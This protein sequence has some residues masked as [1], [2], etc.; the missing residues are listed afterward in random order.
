MYLQLRRYVAPHGDND[1]RHGPHDLPLSHVNIFGL[2]EPCPSLSSLAVFHMQHEFHRVP[3]T[4]LGFWK[5]DVLLTGEGTFIKAYDVNKKTLLAKVEVFDGQAVHGIIVEDGCNREPTILVWGGCLVRR[6][7]A[8]YQLSVLNFELGSLQEADDWILD[9][10]FAPIDSEVARE[11]AIV[12]AHN[13]LT[14]GTL[15]GSLDLELKVLLPGSNCILYAAHVTWLSHFKCLIASGTAFGD[16][17][18]WS[19]V[20]NEAKGAPSVDHETHYNFSAHDGS[21]F[22]VQISSNEVASAL[23]GRS[24]VLASC[25]DDRTIR[26]W[27]ISDLSTKRL[28]HA[29]EERETGFGPKPNGDS[30]GPTCLAK[31]MG[32]GSRIW[33]ARFLLESRSAKSP[34]EAPV[35]IEE[36]ST[37]S[38]GEDASCIFWAMDAIAH[39]NEGP[40]FSM[41]QT[42]AQKSHTGK[43]IWSVIIDQSLRIAT[44]GADG[45]IAIRSWSGPRQVNVPSEVDRKLLLCEGKSDNFK[46][47]AF[48]APNSLLATTDNGR[49]IM[50]RSDASFA[51]TSDE[52]SSSIDAL[53]GYSTIASVA[54]IAFLAGTSG[55]VYAYIHGSDKV[56]KIF[57][58]G[59]KVATLFAETVVDPLAQLSPSTIHL[60]ITNVNAASAQLCVLESDFLTT[61]SSVEAS[62]RQ[63]ELTLPDNFVVTSFM[64]ARTNLGSFVVLGSRSGS[65]AVFDIPLADVNGSIA[66]TTLC[67]LVH[68]KEA[69]TSIAFARKSDCAVNETVLFSTGRDGTY[70]AHSLKVKDHKLE[71]CLIHQLALP[72][73]PNVEGI[74]HSV[75]GNL[76]VWGFRSKQFVVFDI[77]TQQEVMTVEC[78]GAHRTWAFQPCEN[79]GTFFWIKA[80]KLY[81]KTQRD[82]PFQSI[83]AGGHGREI[84]AVAVSKTNPQLIA[85]GAEDTNIKLSTYSSR[86]SLKTLHT[87]QKH[88][89]GTQH[90]QWSADSNHLFSSGGFEEFFIWRIASGVPE[91]GIGVVCESSHPNSGTSDLR[92]TH[93]SAL[94]VGVSAE[95]PIFRITMT[96]SDSTLREWSYHDRTWT[97]LSEGSYL[98]SCLTQV[99]SLSPRTSLT[100][101]IDAKDSQNPLIT[102]STDGHLTAWATPKL[103]STNSSR[104]EQLSWLS[105]HQVHQN[106]ILSLTSYTLGDDSILLLSTGDDNALGITRLQLPGHFPGSIPQL[107]TLL[108]P[109]AHAAAISGL[110]VL[111]QVREPNCVTEELTIC[112]TSVDQRLKAWKISV[113][114][115]QQGVDGIEVKYLGSR[116]S[117][118]ADGA[119][120]EGVRLHDDEDDDEA[121]GVLVYGVGMEVWTFNDL[122][123]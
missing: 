55:D 16:V 67:P 88:N 58:T 5:H 116:F 104:P 36:V 3:V 72:F 44:G 115:A 41:R 22:G 29:E 91:L 47:F 86:N 70:A 112:T 100:H 73:G 109:R 108:I 33:S 27:D 111:S 8:H 83:N 48:H 103:T 24:H 119:G 84:K 97:L 26:I 9:A 42:D 106:S 31:V 120:V 32:H 82:L 34:E 2:A 15:N 51:L 118:V 60:L 56:V 17:I 54:G 39:P 77:F 63:I 21:V 62:L 90:L 89:T 4:A 114:V 68:G 122:G 87:L 75:Q 65:I 46:N 95:S 18:V 45:S 81:W 93:F 49:L 19:C 10:A 113:D 40:L 59:R 99:V 79:G 30:N 66:H 117:A 101:L 78:G 43:N 35:S 20:L 50:L 7:R 92:I 25:S 102:A 57:S 13:S 14:V 61:A 105:R 64:Q 98:T 12:T 94:S 96:Y 123:C 11:V 37:V 71:L 69:V 23:G 80:S 74:G 85:S 53:R 110:A 107:R 52:V 6:L 1:S 28:T 38:F 76:W 121:S